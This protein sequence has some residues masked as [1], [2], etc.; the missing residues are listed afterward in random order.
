MPIHISQNAI[1][2]IPLADDNLA[3]DRIGGILL[4]EPLKSNKLLVAL[5]DN[6][7]INLKLGLKAKSK[8]SNII[9]LKMALIAI[10]VISDKFKIKDQLTANEIF[11][12][13]LHNAIKDFQKTKTTLR[14]DG[15][16][17]SATLLA[18]DAE[19]SKEHIFDYEQ[20][21]YLGTLEPNA[22]FFIVNN[23]SNTNPEFK[24][25]I[26]GGD[27]IIIKT[28][29]KIGFRYVKSPVENNIIQGVPNEIFQAEIN[30]HPAVIAKNL[31][32]AEQ[33]LPPLKSVGLAKTDYKLDFGTSK[34]PLSQINSELGKTAPLL[35]D[36]SGAKQYKIKEGDSLSQI[37]LENYYGGVGY[38]IV[39][40]YKKV[41]IFTLPG[42]TPFSEANRHE[43]ARFQFYHNLLYYYNSEKKGDNP[44]KEWGFRTNGYERYSVDHLDL[45]NI[46]DNKFQDEN[47]EN[48][49]DPYTALPNY[50]RFLKKMEELNSNSKMA[51]DP[52]GNTT[53][54]TTV[55]GENIWIPSRKFADSM[56]HFLNF[57]HD[58][59]LV[60]E[61]DP[62]DGSSTILN[63]IKN[64][65]LDSV[66]N[67]L[68][69][70]LDKISG[71]AEEV[72]T[73]AISLY[74]ETVNFFISAY[75]YVTQS[76]IDYWP[77]GLGG[78][79]GIGGSIT[80]GIPVKTKGD[81][82]K[83]IYRK[84][85]K[86]DELT[87][88]YSRDMIVE[89]G[90]AHAEGFSVG[91]GQ[92]SGHGHSKKLIGYTYGFT[93]DAGIELTQT[94]EYEFPIRQNETALLTMVMT[95]FVDEPVRL[96]AK[97]LLHLDILNV[98]ARK[99]LTKTEL[100]YNAKV[101]A[102]FGGSIGV[103]L[104]DN[105][106][107][108]RNNAD[109]LDLQEETNGHG[110]VNNILDKIPSVG[111][112]GSADF[113][114]GFSYS[115]EFKFDKKPFTS[116]YKGRVF[117]EIEIDYKY[118]IDGQLNMEFIEDLFKTLSPA[119]SPSIGNNISSFFNKLKDE[120]SIEK[121]GITLGKHYK[122]TR[123]GSPNSITNSDFEFAIV[124]KDDENK[125]LKYQ[126][127]NVDKEVYLYFGASSGD[128]GS[129]AEPGT[130]VK[131]NFNMP[132]LYD[133]WLS[134]LPILG[135][136][137]ALSIFKGIEF[138]KKVGIFNFDSKTDSIGD[139]GFCN[140]IIKALKL[141]KFFSS[142][143]GVLNFLST[144]F[145]K[146]INNTEGGLCLNLKM[147]IDFG[148]A[149]ELMTSVLEFHLKKLYLKYVIL[150]DL[151]KYSL[152]VDTNINSQKEKIQKVLDQDDVDEGEEQYK[153]MYS[154]ETF[155]Y[156]KTNT[157]VDGLLLYIDRQIH[158]N[159]DSDGDYS[160]AVVKFVTGIFN[161]NSYMKNHTPI[162]IEDTD[163]GV[164]AF[165]NIFSFLTI[166]GG[167]EVKLE[168]RLKKGFQEEFE[169]GAD[170][171]VV[172]E[173]LEGFA[174]INFQ[175]TFYENG[176]LTDLPYNDPLR[177]LYDEIE[178]LLGTKSNN[179][180]VGAKTLFQALKK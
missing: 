174:E 109:S 179:K 69:T 29:E 148:N 7:T 159:G 125:T 160:N 126:G 19:L 101:G 142:D 34:V 140:K 27:E 10:D 164:T 83:S 55:T 54:F 15:I 113:N 94:T 127:Q 165:L 57:R 177:S 68:K 36:D 28:Q 1:N 99:Y 105:I 133:F 9:V 157:D 104:G 31:K 98:D 134:F 108:H 144:Y 35:F 45:V 81:I 153:K 67:R 8:G 149:Y 96:A 84:M 141:G 13:N 175:P 47:E 43:D 154:N 65:A 122:F 61:P 4:N 52:L 41:P 88:V 168:S 73:D 23:T 136:R 11:D 53:S 62:D 137:Y 17:D 18:I 78:K 93:V 117:K 86:T 162:G 150:Y 135:P 75:N 16:V 161:M 85:S 6:D 25:I 166:L 121:K 32:R 176:K 80:W 21:K 123:K 107:I 131:F 26:E 129:L 56:Y 64:E 138:Q 114:G 119:S 38:V 155:H 5:A 173:S 14:S 112:N 143:S 33:G 50:Y 37:V 90:L 44:V 74:H 49:G 100:K 22:S 60:E 124:H 146:L 91:V 39:D 145:K 116:G 58:E 118:F 102:E 180:R 2:N 92:Y 172:G 158:D 24:I 106:P 42:R 12:I 3:N 72:K 40:P 77:R 66:I 171:G 70:A 139:N 63:Y 79:F 167:L 147:Q 110:L 95:V 130:E 115:L 163:Y 97:I 111:I 59:M 178:I 120:L 156:N 82:Q 76:L 48:G 132:T 87:L 103:D 30:K 46:F 20:K 169:G 170:G 51:F 71:L 152:L 128:P 89:V 151:P